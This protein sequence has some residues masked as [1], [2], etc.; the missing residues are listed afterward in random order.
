MKEELTNKNPF[1]ISML[2]Y[3]R[4]SIV[5]IESWCSATLFLTAIMFYIIYFLLAEFEVRIEKTPPGRGSR[6]LQFGQRN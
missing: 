1:V 6:K 5:L 4:D 2:F 3:K